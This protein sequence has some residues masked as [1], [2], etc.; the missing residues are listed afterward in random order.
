MFREGSDL[1][2]QAANL[3][4]QL[5]RAPF[6]EWAVMERL[7]LSLTLKRDWQLD[8][9]NTKAEKDASVSLAIRPAR[10]IRPILGGLHHQYACLIYDRHRV[11]EIQRHIGYYKYSICQS[12]LNSLPDSR[13]ITFTG[14]RQASSSFRISM[15]AGEFR[16]LPRTIRRISGN[17][18]RIFS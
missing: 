14:Q 2:R 17:G 13:M 11:S 1:V 8:G 15:S 10:S 6:A 3:R 5:P 9:C 16:V 18:T 7:G 12:S 4:G